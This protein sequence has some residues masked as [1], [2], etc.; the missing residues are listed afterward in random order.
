MM[1]ELKRKNDGDSSGDEIQSDSKKSRTGS[2]NSGYKIQKI[3]LA[4][5]Q[6][7]GST[8]AVPNKDTASESLWG[9]GRLGQ[10]YIDSPRVWRQERASY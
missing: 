10:A 8:S 2:Q 9:V 4:R 1:R 6:A 3:L 7:I 5:E